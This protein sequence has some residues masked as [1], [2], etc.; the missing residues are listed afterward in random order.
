VS[1]DKSSG[2]M[3]SLLPDKYFYIRLNPLPEPYELRA[4]CLCAIGYTGTG[5]IRRPRPRAPRRQHCGARAASVRD[6]GD[7]DHP[8]SRAACR[9][10]QG[11]RAVS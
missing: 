7:G 5:W 2:G 9:L 3:A 4:F 8:G 1:Y 6:G 11:R 10:A